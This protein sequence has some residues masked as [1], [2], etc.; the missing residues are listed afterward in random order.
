MELLLNQSDETG[1]SDFYPY[2]YLASD[3]F[4]PGYSF[5][6]LPLAAY[7][8]GMRG[9]GNTWLQR[10]RFLALS[11]FG[12]KA[13]IY[14][15]GARYEVTRINLP[16]GRAGHDGSE[17]GQV[18]R[19]AARVCESCGYHHPREQHADVCEHC[20]APLGAALQEM[21]HMQTVTTRRRER[22]SADEEERNRV[23]FEMLTSYRFVPRGASPGYL[24]GQVS[25]GDAPLA[26][27][28]YGDAAEIRVINLGRKRRKNKDVHGFW[29][30]LLQGKWL[31]ETDAAGPSGSDEDDDAPKPEDVTTKARVIPFVEDRRN[32][33]VFRWAEAIDQVTSQGI[34]ATESTTMQYALERGIEAS[35]QLEDSE[36]TS[37]LLPDVECRG[38][39]MLLEAAEG[40]AGVLRR[41]QAEPD[42]LATAATEA[43]RIIHVDPDTGEETDD[44]CVRGCY[45]C[46]LS[47]GNQPMHEQI[48]RR[49]AVEP[50]L[51][52]ACAR[53]EPA[54]PEQLAPEPAAPSQ[55]ANPRAQELLRLLAER[56]LR[57]PQE[58]DAEV[59]GYDGVVDIVYRSGGL[60]TAVIFE[61]SAEPPD[62]STLQLVTGWNVIRV[63]DDTDLDEV[64]SANPSVF[65]TQEAV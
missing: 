15:E 10:P 13:L 23:G 65:G 30:D 17:A 46:L 7:I 2:R 64:V 40:G 42:A 31:N 55:V 20:R 1:Q 33:L 32:I 24:A 29:L 47:Y 58:V 4:L 59:A 9:R 8:P 60:T 56:E 18:V 48:D 51:R 16:R 44:A 3:G 57:T 19:L 49:R 52:L 21:L 36:L 25:Y 50:L 11:E 22:I 41:L 27:L 6:R 37:E 14:H 39:T 43:L 28:A 12:P 34:D 5:P 53:V 61:D 62:T 35:F 26:E 54:V 38:R 63:H 45:R